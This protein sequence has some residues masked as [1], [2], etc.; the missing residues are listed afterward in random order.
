MFNVIPLL[1]A[2]KPIR[3]ILE[4]QNEVKS[5]KNV[6]VK[7]PCYRYYR[8]TTTQIVVKKSD[9]DKFKDVDKFVKKLGLCTFSDHPKENDYPPLHEQ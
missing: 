2:K 9:K 5:V 8:P 4:K 6:V 7:K 1:H 3:N